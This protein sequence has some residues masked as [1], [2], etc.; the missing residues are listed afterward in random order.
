MKEYKIL[1]LCLSKNL[2]IHIQIFKFLLILNNFFNKYFLVTKK[3]QN[4]I[5]YKFAHSSIFKFFKTQ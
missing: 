4:K 3:V 1:S 5:K 2:H